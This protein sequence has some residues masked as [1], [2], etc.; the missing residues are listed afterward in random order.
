AR[1]WWDY[2]IIMWQHHTPEQFAALKTI[3][4][5]GGQWVGRNRSLPEFLRNNDLR[6]YAENIATDF[7][8]EYHRY[9]PDRTNSWKFL[10]AREWYKKDRTGKEALKR[11]PSLNDPVWIARIRE[12]L[13]DSAKFYAP[14]RPF[15]YSLGDEAGIANL[16]AFWDFDFSD[17]SIVP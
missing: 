8:S 11:R 1:D 12:R 7:Y 4:I 10:E 6:W 5:D 16:A 15:F 2:E 17:E 13:I 9:F 14:Y 3:G